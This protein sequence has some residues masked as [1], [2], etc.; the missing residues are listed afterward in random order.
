MQFLASAVD[1]ARI[2]ADQLIVSGG[3]Q[4][5]FGVAVASAARLS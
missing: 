1:P 5:E 4:E 2:A 3:F